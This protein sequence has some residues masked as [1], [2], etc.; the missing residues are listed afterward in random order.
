VLEET[1]EITEGQTYYVTWVDSSKPTGYSV[2]DKWNANFKVIPNN[3]KLSKHVKENGVLQYNL[4]YKKVPMINDH[5][6]SL[7]GW[8]LKLDEI[9]NGSSE[10]DRDDK[11][12]KGILNS[13]KDLVSLFDVERLTDNALMAFNASGKITPMELDTA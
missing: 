12:I 8:I 6:I 7:Y 1:T 3:I 13:I 11:S 9:I 5:I 2:G 4:C 10:F